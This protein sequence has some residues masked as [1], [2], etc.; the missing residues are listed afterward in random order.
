MIG[1]DS[2]PARPNSPPGRRRVDS[3]EYPRLK[4]AGTCGVFVPSDVEQGHQRT[5]FH[6]YRR[7]RT[8]G[9]RARTS[10]RS[11][12]DAA[13][14]RPWPGLGRVAVAEALQALMAEHQR[15]N[16]E[17]RRGVRDAVDVHLKPG[18]GAPGSRAARGGLGARVRRGT[19]RSGRSAGHRA[20]GPCPEG[21]RRTG[22]PRPAACT[23]ASASGAR[24]A[25]RSRGVPRTPR[26]R[27][28]SPGQRELTGD[29]IAVSMVGRC[30]N[31]APRH[32]AHRTGGSDV[33][34]AVR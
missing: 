4:I 23:G 31:R 8:D 15:L 6:R 32:A 1:R 34:I 28:G 7:R 26:P 12:R 2:T 24:D 14:V 20:R 30:G 3:F 19:P 13:T 16:D 22:G 25:R 5:N 27:S 29:E 21:A 33:L 11:D 18:R 10:H 17:E 9:V